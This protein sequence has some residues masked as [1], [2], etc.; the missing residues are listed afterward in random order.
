[1]MGEGP[2]QSQ[3]GEQMDDSQ[4]VALFWQTAG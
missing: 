1:M 4:I 2:D 3:G